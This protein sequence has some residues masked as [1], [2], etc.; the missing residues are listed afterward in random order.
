MDRLLPAWASPTTAA[1]LVF[2]TSTIFTLIGTKNLPLGYTLRLA[3]SLYRIFRPRFS[4]PTTRSSYPAL[5][6]TKNDSKTS[7]HPLLFKHHVTKTKVYLPDI[8]INVHKSNSTFFVD[9]DVSRAALL[10]SLL[11]NALAHLPSSSGKGPK[12]GMF[13][14]AG[15]GCKFLRPIAPLEGY[16][17]SSRILAWEGGE[18]GALYTVTY[19]LRLGVGKKLASENGREVELQG[20]PAALIRD[21]KL[22]TGVFAV[23]VTRYV[24]KTGREGVSPET[25]LRTAGL[26]GDDSGKGGEGEWLDEDGVKMAVKNGMEYVAGCVL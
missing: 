19:F 5:D 12:P 8:D 24:F 6:T 11:G 26:L 13:L 1:I 4:K 22:R 16:E 2:A 21:E 10:S 18:K 3:P 25:V 9:A 7:A 23:M 17:V 14:L 15:V 20:G